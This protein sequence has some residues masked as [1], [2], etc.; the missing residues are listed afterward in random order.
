MCLLYPIRAPAIPQSTEMAFPF[1]RYLLK[2]FVNPF[3]PLLSSVKKL[4]S[5]VSRLLF[6]ATCNG[7]NIFDSKAAAILL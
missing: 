1:C 4:I 7:G 6:L 5:P 3:P 2:K